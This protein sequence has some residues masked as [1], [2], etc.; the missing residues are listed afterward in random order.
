M[1]KKLKRKYDN[2][3]FSTARILQIF[4]V[5]TCLTLF[6][7]CLTLSDTR[8]SASPPPDG[9]SYSEF[10]DVPYPSFMTLESKNSFTYTRKGVKAG[11]VSVVGRMSADEIGAYY[12]SH[13]PGHGWTPLAEAQ[14]GKLI[15]TWT[16]GQKALTI[17]ATPLNLSLSGDI[18]VELWVAPPHTKGDLDQRIVYDSGPSQAEPVVETKPVRGGKK[19]GSFSEEDI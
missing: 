6:S 10:M 5:M 17:I 8:R 19:R 14:S 11:V 3:N 2:I 15:S 9:E 16:K 4:L 7:G 1:L 18:R 13:L 12:D